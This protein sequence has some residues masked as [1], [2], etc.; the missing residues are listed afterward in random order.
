MVTFFALWGRGEC[1]SARL[2][3]AEIIP[4]SPEMS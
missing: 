1:A 4:Y 3:I 2:Q